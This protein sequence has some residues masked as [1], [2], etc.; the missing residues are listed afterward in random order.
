MPLRHPRGVT[1]LLYGEAAFA[2]ASDEL[3][4]WLAGR[5]AFVVTTPRVWELHGASLHA[6]LAA[7]RAVDVL[8]VPEGEEA[9]TLG[10][11][12]RLWQAM[13][14]AGG[15]RDSRLLAFGGGSVGDLAGFVAGAFLRGIAH[16][17]LPTTLL[18]QVDAAVGGK[19]GI[20]LPGAKNSVGLFNHPFAV[21]AD[22][23]WLATLDAHQRRAG[24][25]EAVK[26]AFLL[27]PPLFAEIERRLPELLAGDAGALAAVVPAAAAIKVRVVERDPEEAGE[28]AL[29]NF[30]HT[31][32]HALEV[33]TGYRGLQHG[34]AVGWGMLFALR[35]ARRR[36]LEP[37]A[38]L[39]LERVL[40]GL[41]LPPVPDV[42]AAALLE[43]LARDKKARESG[44]G[45][46]LP[47]ALGRGRWGVKV[48]SDEVAKEL[49]V[50]LADPLG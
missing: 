24:L 3:A 45:W 18:A 11:A 21:V 20:D 19:T 47:G 12:G 5:R 28:R 37:E 36:G 29:L 41:S 2:T 7:A 8:T 14:V 38:A 1:H 16:T 49:A 34:D 30:G 31:L 26:M 39:R 17:Q 15:K 6:P 43:L 13:L 4:A 22:T 23:R 9:K 32:G 25:V 27:D 46:V 50:F 44:I 35:L 42:E 33:A 40:V 48:P 10:E